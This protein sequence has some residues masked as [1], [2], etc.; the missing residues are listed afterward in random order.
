MIDEDYFWQLWDDHKD[1]L[2]KLSG[3]FHVNRK[4]KYSANTCESQFEGLSC[5]KLMICRFPQKVHSRLFED[6]WK[7]SM[8]LVV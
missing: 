4:F 1:K 3:C 8:M 2:C 6:G 5:L 7:Q